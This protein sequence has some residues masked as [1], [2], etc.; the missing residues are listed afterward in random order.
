MIPIVNTSHD[1]HF[2]L[3]LE[4][5]AVRYLDPA[6]NYLIL[7]Q[8]SPAVIIGRYQNTA[9]EVHQLYLAEHQ[10]AVVR[11]LSGGGAVY[12]DMGNLNFSLIVSTQGQSFNDFRSFTL[13]VIET[14]A[15]Y[16]VKAELSSRNDITIE[17]QKFSGNAQYRTAHH[18]LHHGTILF[19]SD[20]DVVAKVLN[21]RQDKIAS[22]GIKSVRSRVTN[23]KPYLPKDVTLEAFSATLATIIGSHNQ[24]LEPAYAWSPQDQAAVMDLVARRY[25]TWDWNWGKSPAFNLTAHE[26]FAQGSIDVRLF[27]E[28]GIIHACRIYGDFLGQRDIHEFEAALIQ[29]RYQLGTIAPILD[30][31]PIDEYFGAISRQEV[32]QVLFDTSPAQ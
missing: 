32:L 8:N 20:L 9:E 5:Y 25:G 10:I 2:N 12:H 6:H 30:A 15:H 3:A 11:R 19:D 26:K 4:E 28:D 31:L 14:L 7:W 18:L 1:P 22:K 27:V 13:P 21:V 23:I 24:G 29:Q 17:G 16:G